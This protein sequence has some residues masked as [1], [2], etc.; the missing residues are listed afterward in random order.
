MIGT[1]YPPVNGNGHEI[2]TL[3]PYML[4]ETDGIYPGFLIAVAVSSGENPG[5]MPWIFCAR[6]LNL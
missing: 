3:A 6:Y 4:V 2:F 1:P 5:D